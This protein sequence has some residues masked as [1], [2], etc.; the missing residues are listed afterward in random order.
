MGQAFENP[1]WGPAP[2]STPACELPPKGGLR[3]LVVE[4]APVLSQT[5]GFL[6]NYL[7]ITV[8][9]LKKDADLKQ[10]LQVKQPMAIMSAID[11]SGQDGCDLPKEVAEHDG[12]LP[13]LLVTASNP[14]SLAVLEGL[15]KICRLRNVLKIAGTPGVG[16]LVEFLFKAGRRSGSR[17]MP[18]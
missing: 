14:A 18:V 6:C 8:E 13:V 1:E 4:D 16:D 3:V 5:V 10:A 9:T 15:E 7:G 2:L 11:K 17:L 12:S